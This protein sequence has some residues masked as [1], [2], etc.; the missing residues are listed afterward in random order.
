MR[1]LSLIICWLLFP[2]KRVSYVTVMSLLI[3]LPGHI[4]G[5]SIESG[6]PMLADL[7]GVIGDDEL[8]WTD[9]VTGKEYAL[10]GRP[11]GTAFI[12]VSDP[13]SPIF[14]GHLTLAEGAFESLERDIKVYRDHAFIVAD[15]AGEHG[16][17]VFDL[18]RLRG[19][20]TTPAT[21]SETAHY[22]RIHSAHSIVIN[23]ETGAAFVV[24]SNGGGETCAGGLHMIDI[25]EPAQ[26]EFAG[27]FS[28]TGTGHRGTG[29][30]HYAQCVVYRGP[31]E[32]YR[33]REICFVA[34]EVAVVIADVTDRENPVALASAEYPGVGDIHH[35]RLAEDHRYFF[36]GDEGEEI[37][38]DVTELEDPVLFEE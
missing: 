26:P 4:G 30:I 14:V 19:V 31:D 36:L 12:D 10:V 32:Q 17:Q 37:V 13:K 27:C 7:A 16:V 33:G 35:G 18:T 23:A 9:P 25:R 21:F 22:D 5:Q 3:A 8:G 11:N 28:H 20:T 15:G 29:H 1:R 6:P 2:M 24:G 38:W 34:N